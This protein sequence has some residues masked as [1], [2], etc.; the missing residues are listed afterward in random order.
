MTFEHIADPEGTAAE[1]IRILRPGGYICARTVNRYGYVRLFSGL[2]P[3]ALHAKVLHHIQPERKAQDV[4]PTLYRLN[5][6]RDLDA[7]F[8]GC[9]VFCY[10]DSAEPSYYFGRPSL[11]RAFSLFHKLAPDI[12]ATGLCAFIRK[13]AA[14]MA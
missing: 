11:W 8:R 6:V 7:H 2:V 1:L 3:N 9:E 13:P 10:R 14:G 12:F 4:F 5:S